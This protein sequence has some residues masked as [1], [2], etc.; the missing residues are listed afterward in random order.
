MTNVPS[1]AT[2][3]QFVSQGT[4]VQNTTETRLTVS[5]AHLL[6]VKLVDLDPRGAWMCHV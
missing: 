1:I 2:R 3:F 4:S 6:T 5:H